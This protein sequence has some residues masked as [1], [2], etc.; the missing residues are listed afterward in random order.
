MIIRTR[1]RNESL[2]GRLVHAFRPMQVA[3]YPLVLPQEQFETE[4]AR[5]TERS[6]RRTETREFALI[7]FDFSDRQADDRKIIQLAQDLTR[8]LRISDTIGWFNL[9]LAVLLP[10]T[11]QYGAVAVAN[12]LAKIASC[13]GI[14]V[15]TTVSIYPWDDSLT[16]IAEE[17]RE[18]VQFIEGRDD[19]DHSDQDGGGFGNGGGGKSLRGD[20]P[21]STSGPHIR[22]E[23]TL[24][25]GNDESDGTTLMSSMGLSAGAT[26][27]AVAPSVAKAK[28]LQ[29]GTGHSIMFRSE[30]TPVWKRTIDIVGSGIGILI[31]SPFFIGAR[32]QRRKA[33]WYFEIPNY[34]D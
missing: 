27:T 30:R 24:D 8:R 13:H 16:K 14:N 1:R 21:H 3:G 23:R 5:E 10:E 7:T 25:D 15:E 26:A 33:V 20:Q 12:D 34:G 32:R 19:E 11:S 31:L 2:I 22:P 4:I 17:L 9:R 18:E 29:Y 28:A 6:N